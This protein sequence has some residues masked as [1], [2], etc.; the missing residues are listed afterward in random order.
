MA[1]RQD[2]YI[3]QS[4]ILFTYVY[5]PL[6]D[7]DEYGETQPR[8]PQFVHITRDLIVGEPIDIWFSALR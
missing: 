1:V 5:E 2:T 4:Y 6:Y 7:N 8:Y 3:Y